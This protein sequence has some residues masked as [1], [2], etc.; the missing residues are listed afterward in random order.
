MRRLVLISSR[1][2]G[3]I[4]GAQSCHRFAWLKVTAFSAGA[5]AVS[6]P[7]V[8]A[9]FVL[10]LR[11]TAFQRSAPCGPF[12]IWVTETQKSVA[13]AVNVSPGAGCDTPAGPL[14]WVQD[15]MRPFGVY[16]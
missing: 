4:A 2:S 12:A 11:S 15:W 9:P 3:P 16:M 8:K 6:V 13:A 10:Q 14:T 7:M 1:P 5:A